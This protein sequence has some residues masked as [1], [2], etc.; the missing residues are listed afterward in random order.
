[1]KS[2]RW[3]EY[4]IETLGEEQDEELNKLSGFVIVMVGRIKEKTITKEELCTILDNLFEATLKKVKNKHR[5]AELLKGLK[6]FILKEF[7][8]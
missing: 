4:L 1:V 6:I 5:S 8:N 3:L 2:Q 7:D